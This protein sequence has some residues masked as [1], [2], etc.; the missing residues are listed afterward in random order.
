MCTHGGSGSVPIRDEDFGII[1]FME[2]VHYL[3]FKTVFQ[4][5]GLGPI[6]R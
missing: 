3:L 1:Y 4:G 5:I 2:F 6:L